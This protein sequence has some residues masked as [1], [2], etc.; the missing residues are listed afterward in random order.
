MTD[1]CRT[2]ERVRRRGVGSGVGLSDSFV[3]DRSLEPLND[4]CKG[5]GPSVQM[6]RNRHD[7]GKTMGGLRYRKTNLHNDNRIS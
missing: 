2:C 1:M 7:M 6:V 4:Q 3:G 5:S